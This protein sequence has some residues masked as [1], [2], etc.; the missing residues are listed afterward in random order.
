MFLVTTEQRVVYVQDT[1]PV[2]KDNQLWL[3]DDHVA[4]SLTE[5]N[6][7]VIFSSINPP[8]D[9]VSNKYLWVEDD[10]L[11]NPNWLPIG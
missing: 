3:S 10:F 7:Q 6:A 9:F 4:A 5:D 1:E 2:F 11:L 8:E